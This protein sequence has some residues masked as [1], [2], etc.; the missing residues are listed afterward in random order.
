M[1][2]SKQT[3][4]TVWLKYYKHCAY[5]GSEIEYKSMQVDHIKAKILGG[6]DDIS[7]LNPA[8]FPC[9]N[10]KCHSSLEEFR[11]L[12]KQMLN[13]KLQYLFKSKTKMNVA[14]NFGAIEL[15]Q[16]DGIFYFEKFTKT[17]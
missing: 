16:W 10:Y 7:N 12:T 5:C 13:D 9:N 11:R 2:I 8:C 17:K 6:S 14:I 3:R 1:A 15:K 4:L